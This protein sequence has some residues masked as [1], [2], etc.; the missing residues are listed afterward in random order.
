MDSVAN[1]CNENV[2]NNREEAESSV[3]CYSPIVT[4][5]QVDSSYHCP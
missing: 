5:L 4:E 3:F 1:A 2:E